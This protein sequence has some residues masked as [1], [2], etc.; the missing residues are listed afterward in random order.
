VGYSKT[1]AAKVDTW[2]RVAR[3]LLYEY[4]HKRGYPE[5]SSNELWELIDAGILLP[6]PLRGGQNRRAIVTRLF[7]SHTDYVDTGRT[8]RAT[9]YTGNSRQL[10]VW[11]YVGDAGESCEDHTNL[12]VLFADI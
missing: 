6:I 1:N 12:D 3:Y 11:R 5:V 10:V 4:Y 8:R 7:R 2:V 9:H